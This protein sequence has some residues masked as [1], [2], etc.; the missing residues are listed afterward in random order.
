MKVSP[1]EAVLGVLTLAVALLGGTALLAR[2]KIDEWKQLR[3]DQAQVRME[4]EQDRRLVAGRDEWV[5]R[6]SEL[7][8]ML[9]VFPPDKKMDIH[10]LSVMDGAASKHGVQISKRQAGDEEQQGEVYELPIESKEWEGTLDGLVHFLFDMQ[11]EGAMLDVRQLFVK[12]KSQ[13]VLRGRFVL[14]CAYTRAEKD[15]SE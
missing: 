10:W 7:S 8:K 11:K 5:K 13:N 3:A 4:I 12:P 6:L 9:P 1:R 2:P 14:Y 15:I